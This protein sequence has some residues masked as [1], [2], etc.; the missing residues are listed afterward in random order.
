MSYAIIV[1]RYNEN[2][3]WLKSEMNHSIIY[4]KGDKLNLSNEIMLENK[5]RESETYLRYII[6]HY[7]H[8]PDV[9]VF[10][11]ARIADHTG[12]DDVNYLIQIKDEA[13]QHSKSQNHFTHNDVGRNENF[14]KDWNVRADGYFLSGNYKNNQPIKFSTWFTQNINMYYP[15]PICV[16]GNAIFA[17]KKELILG[18]SLDYYNQLRG[19]VAHHEN[20]TEGHF[21]ERSWWYIFNVR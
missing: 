20:P 1:S 21:C 19:E 7:P 2:I 3:E 12:G 18:K 6:E 10:T 15:N 17:V 11:Q 9:V 14:D 16:Y 8:F 5:G 13:L 4:N